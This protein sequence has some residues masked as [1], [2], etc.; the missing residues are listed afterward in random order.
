MVSLF[1]RPARTLQRWDSA[2]VARPVVS[3][4]AVD[5]H[6]H[7]LIGWTDAED[8]S[9]RRSILTRP[10]Y[11]HLFQT[12]AQAVVLDRALS[13][14]AAA[15]ATRVLDAL[16][17]GRSFSIVRG[18]AT[19]ASVEFAAVQNGVEVP[20]GARTLTVGAPVEVR[21]SV[22]NAP[23]A[24]VE[25]LHNGRRLATGQGSATYTGV[26]GEGSYR[27][28]VFYGAVE[29]PWILSN[30]IYAGASVEPITP[31]TSIPTPT[32]NIP[33]PGQGWQIERDPASTA[34]WAIDQH[35]IKVDYQLGGG[36][37]AGQFAALVT[38]LSGSIAV[39]RIEFVAHATQPMRLSVQIRL[40]GARN[41]RWRRSVYLDETPRNFT[42]RLR[43]FESIEGPT[44]LR[45]NV[46]RV[47]S[48]LFVVDT[49]NSVPGS[50]GSVWVFDAKV[51]GGFPDR[52]SGVPAASRSPL[53]AR[54]RD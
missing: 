53:A 23:D 39:D 16:A 13:G 42:A 14:D 21:A 41:Q 26:A 30:A 48:V 29:V 19:P 17:A 40:P 18:I 22:P 5:A 33:Q 9:S 11:E 31:D 32:T 54:Q 45:P 12:L 43:D 15:D 10:T 38:N 8:A 34:T 28:E 3:L 44:T 27:V 52:S 36:A 20:M 24:R 51:G 7:G 35:A 49:L 1:T 4:A 47:Q 46:A 37:P 2:M 6:A 25:L 50:K